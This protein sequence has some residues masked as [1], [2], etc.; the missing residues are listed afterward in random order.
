MMKVANQRFTTRAGF[1][2]VSP[3]FI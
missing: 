1:R 3:I 2:P